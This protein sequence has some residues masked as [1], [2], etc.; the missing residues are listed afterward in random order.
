MPR[1]HGTG[2]DRFKQVANLKPGNVGN[3]NHN[4]VTTELLSTVEQAVTVTGCLSTA[5]TTLLVQL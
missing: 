4:A 5:V 2:R 1:H 3:V